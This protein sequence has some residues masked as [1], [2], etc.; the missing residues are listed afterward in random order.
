MTVEKKKLTIKNWAEDD[1]PREKLISKGRQVLSDAEL[2]AI[3]IGSGNSKMSAVELSKKLLAEAANFNLDNLSKLTVNEL[4]K[5]SGIGEA[6]AVTIVAAME[7]AR[8]RKSTL[9]EVRPVIKSSRV[10]YEILNTYLADLPHEEF[11]MIMVNRAN[12]VLKVQ[13]VGVGGISGTVVD[14][15]IV[16]K[17]ALDH[18]A[19]GIILGHNHPS[20]QLKPSDADRD[21][22]ANIK[23]AGKLMNIQLLD[24]IIVGNNAYFSFVDEGIL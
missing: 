7:L 20:G 24:H 12:K 11:Y 5:F 19:T 1:R 17:A 22:T 6:K 2:L 10:A 4:T 9:E 15:R 16:F 21:I 18:M 13:R 8:R 14:V 23:M 3:L